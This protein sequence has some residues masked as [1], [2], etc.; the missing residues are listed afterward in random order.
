M[1]KKL[2]TNLTPFI[3]LSLKGK[4]EGIIFGGVK[5]LQPT[6]NE[7]YGVKKYD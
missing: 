7:Q 5:P 2:F 1:I 6:P 4:G 3:P